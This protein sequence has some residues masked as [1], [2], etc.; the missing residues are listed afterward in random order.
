[1]VGHLAARCPVEMRC[2]PRRNRLH[3]RSKRRVL[4]GKQEV[5]RESVSSDPEGGQKFQ[6]GV[7]N[8][9]LG[10][11]LAPQRVAMSIP[12]SPEVSDIREELAKLAI[13]THVDGCVNESSILEVAPAIINHALSGPITPL[14]D[15]MFLVPL[16][17]RE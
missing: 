17:N 1:M 10:R 16:K 11:K 15:R 3:V 13:L 9:A 8:Q 14:N 12:L 6:V 2:S 4:T 5:H 7:E